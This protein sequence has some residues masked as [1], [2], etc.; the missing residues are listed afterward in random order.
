MTKLRVTSGK[1]VH[2]TFDNDIT[3]S[4]QIGGGNYSDNYDEPIISDTRRDLP[5]S[6]TAEIAVW[7]YAN[8]WTDLDGDQVAGWVPVNNIIKIMAY[9]QSLP[10][11]T[12]ASDIAI[13]GDLIGR[14]EVK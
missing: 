5:S 6:R 2:F 8:D 1:G 9:L 7:D 13:P 10:N 12:L 3:I 14:E 4:I 11:L